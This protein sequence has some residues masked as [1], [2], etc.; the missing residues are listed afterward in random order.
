MTKGGFTAHLASMKAASTPV[1]VPENSTD[2]LRLMASS[3][4]VLLGHRDKIT[5]GVPGCSCGTTYPEDSFSYFP[6]LH[7][8]HM[9]EEVVSHVLNAAVTAVRTDQEHY[10][11]HPARWRPEG[12]DSNAAI[13]AITNMAAREKGPAR[14]KD[15]ATV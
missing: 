6:I 7:A 11:G 14:T 5:A 10:A 4:D 1:A 13:E 8:Q 15:A 9:A 3:S 2:H 12:H